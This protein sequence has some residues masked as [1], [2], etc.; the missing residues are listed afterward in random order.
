M[1]PSRKTRA[2]RDDTLFTLTKKVMSLGTRKKSVKI[3][4][5]FVYN[6][7]QLYERVV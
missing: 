5:C 7:I 1:S 2:A 3:T 4:T 6:L